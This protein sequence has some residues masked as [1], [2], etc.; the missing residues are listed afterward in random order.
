MKSIKLKKWQMIL[1]VLFLFGVLTAILKAVGIIKVA[2]SEIKIDDITLNVGESKE[3]KTLIM[4]EDYEVEIVSQE[5][6]I[7]DEKI[8]KYEDGKVI[9]LT[10]GE[11]TIRC[12][13]KDNTDDTIKSNKAKIKVSL[14]AEQKKEKEEAELAAK[15]NNISTDEGVRI[16]DYCEQIINSLLK[17]P[18]T[19]EYPGSFLNPFEDWKMVKK[20]NL[21]TI[22][23]Y[24]DAQNSFG[25]MVRSKFIIQV[26]MTDNGQGKATYVQFDGEIMSGKYQK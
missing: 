1:I 18:S 5:Y 7:S 20:N 26:E 11:T 14:T 24:V 21:V 25:A 2:I 13:I 19:A 15:R 23:S 3:V 16:K 9:A 17:S 10:D 12:I 6:E 8:A 22:S 4:P